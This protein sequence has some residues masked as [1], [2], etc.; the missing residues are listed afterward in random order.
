M[1]K[2]LR[3]LLG[4]NCISI[5]DI[6]FSTLFLSLLIASRALTGEILVTSM[7]ISSIFWDCRLSG[8]CVFSEARH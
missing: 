2:A 4:I 6:S 5:T 7:G 8:S 1:R 3:M